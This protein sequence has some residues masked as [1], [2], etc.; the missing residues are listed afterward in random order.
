M[1]LF[2]NPTQSILTPWWYTTTYNPSGDPITVHVTESG[3]TVH[4]E[5]HDCPWE[6]YFVR[7]G[8]D[9]KI[10]LS[11]G[12]RYKPSNNG[13]QSMDG[14]CGNCDGIFDYVLCGAARVDVSD[15]EDKYRQIS[16]SCQ[17][18]GE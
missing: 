9:S 10:H 18:D 8:F 6:L 12:D 13:G 1:F 15:D 2:Q 3:V 7:G 14:L 4:I 11:V 5:S 16:D 17:M